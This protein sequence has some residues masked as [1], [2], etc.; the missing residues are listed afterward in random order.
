[1][2]EPG[3]ASPPAG[4]LSRGEALA[5]L[6]SLGATASRQL[7]TALAAGVAFHHAGLSAEERALVERCYA[8]GAVRVLA[9]TATLA[10]GVNLPARR[11]LFKHAY[12]GAARPD[13]F[14][15]ATM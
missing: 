6:A 7:P 4:G 5:E 2:P 3:P 1:M 15:T 11:V 14:L 10:A 12:Q 13:R 9:A 8:G